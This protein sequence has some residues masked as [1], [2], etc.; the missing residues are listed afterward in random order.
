V[1]E[2]HAPSERNKYWFT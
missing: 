1:V 2:E